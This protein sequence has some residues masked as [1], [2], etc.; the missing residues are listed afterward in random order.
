MQIPFIGQ[1]YEN[2]SIPVSNQICIN[3]YPEQDSSGGGSRN[4]VVLQ[5]AAGI[6]IF[7]DLAISSLTHIRGMH[8]SEK[9]Q[10]LYVVSGTTLYDID[11]NGTVASRGTIAGADDVIMADNGTEVGIANGSAF[12]VWNS[13]TL[14]LSTVND[15]GGGTLN[16]R[17]IGYL[18]GR[19]ILMEDDQRLFMTDVQDGVDGRRSENLHNCHK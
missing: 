17:D 2:R 13:S 6:K 5:S 1:A 15:S 19:F 16:V 12:R 8:Y 14:T 11:I 7:K 9:I 3:W 4:I 10:R 18:D